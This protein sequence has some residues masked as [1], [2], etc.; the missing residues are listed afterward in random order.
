MTI[1]NISLFA[2]IVLLAIVIYATLAPVNLRPRTGHVHAE[3]ML[4][5][6]ALAASLSAAYPRHWGRVAV[7]MVAIAFGLEFLQ[8]LIPTRDPR[9]SDATEKAV[10]ALI[11]VWEGAVVSNVLAQA[12]WPKRAEP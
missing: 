7:T 12:H 9:L 2:F 10:G 4:A 5:F 1:R 11:G 6:A 8:G 3:R